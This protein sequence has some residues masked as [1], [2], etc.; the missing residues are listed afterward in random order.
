MIKNEINSSIHDKIKERKKG[1]STFI[2]SLQ[3]K[4]FCLLV[5]GMKML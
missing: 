4:F 2:K 5:F 3:V 1:Q